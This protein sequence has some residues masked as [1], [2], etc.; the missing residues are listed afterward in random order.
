MCRHAGCE[1]IGNIDAAGPMQGKSVG[2]EVLQLVGVC[3]EMHNR[4]IASMPPVYEYSKDM[5]APCP[6]PRFYLRGKDRSS[7]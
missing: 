1:A 7:S 5:L 6:P 4:T 3:G 2:G